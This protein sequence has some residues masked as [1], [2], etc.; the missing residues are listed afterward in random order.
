MSDMI[1][2]K[3]FPRGVLVAAAA[4][5]GFTLVLVGAARIT[6]IGTQQGFES[7]PV[8]S[9]ALRFEDR[10]D[11]SV[12]VLVASDRDD[13]RAREREVER[14]APGTNGFVR[15]VLRGLARERK[16]Q[17][18]GREPAF[19]LTRW[20]DGRLSLED[21]ETGRRIELDAFGPTNVAAFARLLNVGSE[22]R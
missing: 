2:D 6:R 14:M 13:E 5:L 16:L 21:P 9:R 19:E 8:E 4:L 7:A 17:G 15:S 11:G 3:P 1:S 18:I 22:S 20:A 10:A 12:V